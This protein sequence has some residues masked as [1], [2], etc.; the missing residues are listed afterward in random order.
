M[1]CL[2]VTNPFLAVL[3]QNDKST[4]CTLP[5]GSI[6]AT[7]DDL[8]QPGLVHISSRGQELFAF[9]R[10]IKDHTE[11]LDLAVANHGS[12]DESKTDSPADPQR[13]KHRVHGGR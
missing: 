13:G 3:C 4:F 2:R 12:D 9:T 10:D 11:S 6:I 1:V 8:W 5:V 7:D